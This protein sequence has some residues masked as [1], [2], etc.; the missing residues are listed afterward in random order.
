[1]KVHT[2]TF[3]ASSISGISLIACLVLIANIYSDVQQIWQE[4]DMQISVFR[5]ETD[6]LWRDMMK[7]G[8]KARLRRS[9]AY[10]EAAG[11]PAPSASGKTPGLLSNFH[12]HP[13]PFTAGVSAPAPSTGAA[14]GV[15]QGGANPPSVPPSIQTGGPGGAG[16]SGSNFKQHIWRQNTRF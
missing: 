16:C 4:L 8:Q 15:P 1:M 13:A 10:A 3:L 7:L 11:G 5:A 14:P 12:D 6:D 9:D 2:A